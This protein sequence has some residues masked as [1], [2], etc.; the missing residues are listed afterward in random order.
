MTRLMALLALARLRLR[1]GDPG[2]DEVLEEARR[3]AEGSGALQRMAPTA[4]ARAEAAF[5][6]GDPER[7]AAEVHVAL[8]LAQSKG[9]PWFVGELNYWLWRT[10]AIATAPAGC[11]EP[12]A[13][14]IAGR[15]REAAAAWQ[16]ARLPLRTCARL[17]L[18]DADSAAGSP[19]D[20]RRSRRAPGR[21]ESAPHAARCRV[22]GV[23]RG[24]RASTRGNPCG[25][26]AAE[27]QGAR[28]S[29]ARTCAM[30]RSRSDCI[31]RCARST[32]TWP[33]CWPSWASSRGRRPCAAPS[34]RA[35]WPAR[36]N[37]GNPAAQI[38]QRCR[39]APDGRI[40]KL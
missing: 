21:R 9:H 10:G 37:L 31:V 6:R 33:P 16:R 39:R 15:W 7:V 32:T 28:S 4:C 5:V 22:R 30:P 14:E 29:C 40:V 20:L 24:V 13:L 34:A 25:L 35:G 12:Y 36:R 38:R 27:M 17:S 23:A 2:A 1:R 8:P 3:M 18:G 11:A 26:T 19:C